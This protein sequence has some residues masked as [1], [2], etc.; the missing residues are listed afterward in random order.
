MYIKKSARKNTISKELILI[1][2]AQ[3]L[4]LLINTAQEF[5]C[6]LRYGKSKDTSGSVWALRGSV[7]VLVLRGSVWALRGSVWKLSGSLW[8]LQPHKSDS[9]SNEACSLASTASQR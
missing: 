5:S 8:A 9:R 7:F 6:C 3:D 1:A 4:E 2:F